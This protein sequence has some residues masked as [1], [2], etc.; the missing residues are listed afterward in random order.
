MKPENEIAAMVEQYVTDDP[1][2][3]YIT[4]LNWKIILIL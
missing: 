1:V 3:G 4:T 2:F